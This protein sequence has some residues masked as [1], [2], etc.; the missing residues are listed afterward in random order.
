M[1]L[2]A[3]YARFFRSLN[4][5]Y[6]RAS[7][8]TYEP[9]PWDATPSGADYPFVRLRL[10]PDITTVVGGNESGK[11]QM[12]CAIS[13]ALTGEGFDRSD[14]CRY[15]TFFGVDKTLLV[16]EFGAEFTDITSSD[17]TTIEQMTGLE[18]LGPAQRVAIFRMNV[19][20]KLRI[21]LRQDGIWTAPAHIKAP[22]LLRSIGVPAPFSID[23]DVPLP[24]SVPLEYLVTGKASTALGRNFLRRVWDR[25][26]D[27][28]SWFDSQTTVTERS[29]EV[30]DAFADTR[31]IDDDEL[32]KFALAADLLLKVADLDQSL[33]AELQKAVRTQNGY[34]NSIVDTINAELAKALNF[35]HWWSQDSRFELFV[36]LHEYHLIFMI[37]DRTGRSY[38]FDERS[39]GLKYFLSYFV[40]YLAHQPPEDGGGPELLL[41]DEPDRFLSSSGQQ[42][43]LRIFEDF[44]HPRDPARKPVQ[45]VYVT[46]SPFL[47]DKNDA[48]RIRVVEKGEYD[49]G[50]RVVA[51]VAAN[52]YEP[53]RSAFGGFVAETAFIGNC[54]LMLEGPSDQVLLAGVARW[55]AGR[56]VADRDRLD[57]NTITLVPTGGTRHVPYMVYLARG[58]DIEKPPIIV[59]LDG[60][61]PGDEARE[62]LQAG[63]AYA[64]PLIDD[65][66]VLQVS[67]AE[68]A[69][70]ETDNRGGVIV[71]EDLIPFSIAVEAVKAYC[72]EFVPD[73]AVDTLGLGVHDL[74][75]DG[76][77]V[78][79][80]ERL[81][82]SR[83]GKQRFHLDKVAFARAVI[84]TLDHRGRAQAADQDP[85]LARA[86][87]NFTL[88]LS[89]LARRQRQ[90]VRAEAVD[91]ISSRINRAK[92]Q[93][94][95][96]QRGTARREDVLAL[97]E[98]ISDQ[99]DNSA[100]AE[101]VR[102]T[103]RRWRER[104]HLDEDPRAQID[105]Y[106]ALVK[107]VEALAYQAVRASAD[108]SI[109]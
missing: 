18:N 91:K 99:L 3:I 2:C 89:A 57:L 101:D 30:A 98:E 52:H 55:L 44:A 13:A 8:E 34:A 54:N 67:D 63:G 66:L 27:N 17:L 19:T 35:P 109:T 80:L 22:K 32:R 79:Q 107:A 76:G 104:F 33:F 45:V 40:Q 23:T 82:R 97:I 29:G 69:A 26:L 51:S 96:T 28:H 60:D 43:L 53:L 62:E 77:L 41:M 84:A 70:I 78:A 56:G 71:I 65:R 103:M 59:M 16:P 14:F 4:Y 87:Q 90:A 92:R 102:A 100:D 12:L 42:D 106:P 5:D 6:I 105:D 61:K 24:D 73:I 47:I 48:G 20:P 81:V 75:G 58:R 37:R 85:D 83:S 74:V 15:S 86:Q 21:Y 39:D 93:F 49:E 10:R 46:H 9:D 1:R 72:E 25:F 68:L 11:S 95:R 7:S 31:R 36:A 94:L 38:G 88:L 64:A 108:V 50:T